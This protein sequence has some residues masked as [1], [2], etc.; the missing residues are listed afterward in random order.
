L[1]A[2]IEQLAEPPEIELSTPAV[3]LRMHPPRQTT[4]LREGGWGAG[5]DHRSWF[6]RT[7]FSLGEALQEAEEQVALLAKRFP[8][9]N[10]VQERVLTQA[11]RELLLA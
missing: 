11:G 5:G 7:A 8:H 4:T 3:Y 6:G 9:A 2:L 10:E 1:R